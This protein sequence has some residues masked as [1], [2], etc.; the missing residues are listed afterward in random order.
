VLKL[1]LFSTLYPNAAQPIHGPFVE[2]RLLKLLASG[3]CEARVVAPVPWFPWKSDRFGKYAEFASVPDRERR[4]GVDVLH[5][6]YPLIPKVGMTLAPLLL[7]SAALPTL[8]GLI[9]DGYDFDVIDAH[10]YY[11]DGVAAALLGRWLNRPVTITARGTDINLIPEYRVPRALIRWASRQ[12]AA[13]IAVCEALKT[14]MVGLG[15]DAGQ[16]HVLRNGVDL[17]HFRPV[18][19]ADSRRQLGLSEGRWLLSVGLLIERKGH[20]IPIRALGDLPG[21]SLMIAGDGPLR[22]SLQELADKL[23]VAGRVRFL[24]N[25]PQSELP[26]YYS[27]ADALVL[28]SSREGWANVLL[29]SMACG[30]PVIASS[31][32]GTPEVVAAEE[33]G[34]LMSE[35]TPAG[36]VQAVADLERRSPSRDRTRAYA[37]QFDWMP[38]TKGQLAIFERLVRRAA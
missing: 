36:M 37:E 29:E 27:A 25:V 28:A 3:A 38:T 15:M 35:R 23:G 18:D 24:G 30:T 6:R 1:L 21:W 11:P 9:S 19:R 12:S 16:I 10:Y 4:N 7:A 13:S 26:L 5:P 32:W 17:E 31:V 8:R 14:E 2:R 20:D 33:A 22:Q 34:V